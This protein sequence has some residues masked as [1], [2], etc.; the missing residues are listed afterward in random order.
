MFLERFVE[1]FLDHESPNF[2]LLLF[3]L[4]LLQSD[5]VSQIPDHNDHLM[6][7]IH[8]DFGLRQHHCLTLR[9]RFHFYVEH[10]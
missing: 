8:L 2:F 10:S 6:L 7:P 1:I 9:L 4:M 5:F 3:E